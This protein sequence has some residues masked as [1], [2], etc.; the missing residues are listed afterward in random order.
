MTKP[1]EREVKVPTEIRT[2]EYTDRDGRVVGHGWEIVREESLCTEH[3]R[4]HGVDVA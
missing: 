1:R 3:A 4:E 2:K